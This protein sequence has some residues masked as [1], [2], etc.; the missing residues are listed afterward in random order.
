MIVRLM[1]S[2]CGKSRSV[3]TSL[4]DGPCQKSRD[5]G[6]NPCL[7]GIPQTAIGRNCECNDRSKS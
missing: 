3:V 7:K 5:L 1:A 2:K 4:R 6:E